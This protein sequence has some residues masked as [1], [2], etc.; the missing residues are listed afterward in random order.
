[1]MLAHKLVDECRKAVTAGDSV[2]ASLMSDLSGKI[3][4]AVH[5]DFG[6]IEALPMAAP[7]EAF[8]ARPPF[9]LVVAQ[10]ST[11]SAPDQTHIIALF[12]ESADEEWFMI[13]AK[14]RGSEKWAVLSPT[15][16]TRN[17]DGSSRLSAI[18]REENMEERKRCYAYV[19]NAFA[20]LSCSNVAT[21]DHAAPAA[22]NKKRQ[23]KGNAPILGHKTLVVMVGDR[24]PGKAGA[25]GSHASPRVHLRRGHIRRLGDGRKVWVQS[26]VVGSKHGM[27]TKDYEVRP[28]R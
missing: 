28:T 26:C 16:V 18:G 9:P 14:M 3:A 7:E 23:R 5:F 2:A 6:D 1:M 21:V 13:G 20:V 15:R 4:S 24:T 22:L 27:L 8:E 17:A 25:A 19:K 12:E 10:F 11:P